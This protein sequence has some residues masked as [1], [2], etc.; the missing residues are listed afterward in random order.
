MRVDFHDTVST[1]WI[2]GCPYPFTIERP[3]PKS[4]TWAGVLHREGLPWELY[5]VSEIKEKDTWRKI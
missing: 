5:N 1:L 4:H 2:K 3:I